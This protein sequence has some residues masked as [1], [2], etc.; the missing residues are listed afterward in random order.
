MKYTNIIVLVLVSLLSSISHAQSI[1]L[2]IQ[3]SSTRPAW[4]E[5]PNIVLILA[6]DLGINEVGVYGQLTRQAEGLPSIDTP[7]IDDLAQNGLRFTNMYTPATVCAPTRASILTGFHG[8]HVAVDSNGLNNNGGNAFREVDYTIAELLQQSGYTTGLFGKW[9]QNGMDGTKL[10]P[11]ARSP[12]ALVNYSNPVVTDPLT[13]P[14]AKGFDEFYGYLNHIHAHSYYTNYLW[15]HDTDDSNDIGGVQVD[16]TPSPQDYTHD[17]I[18]DKSIQFIRN[19]AADGKPFFLFGAYTIPHN[20][21]DPPEDEIL[22]NYIVRG[23]TQAQARYAAMVSRLDQ[24]VGDIITVLQDPNSDGDTRDSI[25]SKTIVIFATDNGP[26]SSQANAWFDGNGIYRGLKKSIYEGAHRS[27]FIVHWP[28][29]IKPSSADGDINDSHIGSLTDLFAT[30]AEL[31]GADIPIGLDSRSMLGVLT[32]EPQQEHEFLIWE[33]RTKDRWAIRMDNYKL[34]RSGSVQ[35]YDLATDP[36]ESNNLLRNP[37]PEQ[38]HIANLMQQIALE[39]GVESDLGNGGAQ[40]THIVQYKEWA[41]TTSSASWNSPNNWTGGSEFNTRDI[42]AN[43][44]STGPANNWIATLN[45]NLDNN[46]LAAVVDQTSEVLGL[47]VLGTTGA[48]D[49]LINPGVKLLARNGARVSRSG[50]IQLNGGTLSTIRTIDIRR[51]GE[52]YGQGHITGRH[53]IPAKLTNAGLVRMSNHS[54][55]STIIP[56]TAVNYVKNGSFELGNNTNNG[57]NLSYDELSDWSSNN[58]NA[59]NIN[60]AISNN[61]FDYNYRGLVSN[62]SNE[63]RADLMQT[64][65]YIF[66]G[67][68]IV[69]QFWHRSFANWDNTDSITIEISYLDDTST[70]RVLYSK[71]INP[72]SSWTEESITLSIQSDSL[73]SLASLALGRQLIL[74]FTP[75]KVERRKTSLPPLM[76]LP[77]TEVLKNIIL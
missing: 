54:S 17:L 58:S 69:L 72:T 24:T 48:M 68:P 66:D 60:G 31:A 36:Q 46:T 63:T 22:S 23:Y 9:G 51:K 32:N 57:S 16:T 35:L 67:E 19:H 74:R 41:S 55:A 52:L 29:E 40:N 8:G 15:E 2:T 50:K 11:N 75:I 18:A 10:R 73:A 12:N 53:G 26:A 6:D 49:L 45:N 47:E 34:L 61:A 64:T 21:Y 62:R 30:F 44:F 70:R 71:D 1:D 77:C 25:L 3:E 4:T 33:D 65:D 20:D 14:S 56:D 7:N 59:A 76:Q 27:P 43:N 28:K 37:T 38:R 39:E 42:R 13:T 5:R